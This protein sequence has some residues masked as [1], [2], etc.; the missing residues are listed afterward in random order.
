MTTGGWDED[1]DRIDD[2]ERDDGTMGGPRR[3]AA[4]LAR[5]LSATAVTA[6]VVE[7]VDGSEAAA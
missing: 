6:R 1:A 5:T 7:C 4:A 2:D 3:T